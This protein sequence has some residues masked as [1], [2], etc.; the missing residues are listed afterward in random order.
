MG[1]ARILD[2]SYPVLNNAWNRVE[3]NR[4]KCRELNGKSKMD[5]IAVFD[6]ILLAFES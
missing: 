1:Q 6:E 5:D 2:D 3:T 4:E